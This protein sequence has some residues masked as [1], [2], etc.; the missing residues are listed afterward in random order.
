MQRGCSGLDRGA[1]ESGSAPPLGEDRASGEDLGRAEP[2]LPEG[3][4]P[5]HLRRRLLVYHHNRRRRQLRAHTSYE[6][7]RVGLAR[8]AGAS[9]CY[10]VAIVVHERAEQLLPLL[11]AL[12]GLLQLRGD[13]G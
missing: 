3:M 10:R 6:L 2:R 5:L 9:G 12:S 1:R 11:D 8:R 4:V 13:F 7:A